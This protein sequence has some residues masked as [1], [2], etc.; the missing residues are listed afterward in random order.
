MLDAIA[1]DATSAA[2]MATTIKAPLADYADFSMRT[3]ASSIEVSCSATHDGLSTEVSR[4]LSTW[5]C[6][7]ASDA[8]A[9]KDAHEALAAVDTS[10]ANSI[11]AS[12]AN[13]FMG[14]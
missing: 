4:A 3:I 2:K 5:E 6:L 10:T 8:S 1:T 12:A 7:I 14:I 13:S 9:L 11:Y